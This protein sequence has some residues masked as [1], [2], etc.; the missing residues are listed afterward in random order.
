MGFNIG[1]TMRV[2]SAPNYYEPRDSIARD[3]PRFIKYLM[4]DANLFLIPNIEEDAVEFCRNH[5][6]NM[7]ILTGG[8]DYGVHNERD[9]TEFALI[10][11]M[12]KKKLPIIGI[13]RGM[14]VIHCFFGGKV[15]QGDD[16]FIELHRATKHDIN[17]YG[18]VI[19]VNS[20]HNLKIDES[21]LSK[22]FSVLARCLEDG[23][24]EGF[25]G[26]NILGMMW[27]PERTLCFSD[28][29]KNLIINFL[30]RP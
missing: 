5:N 20:Y 28:F 4:P 13:C 25:I 27:H 7:L 2:T 22:K 10:E 14:Q 9:I 3:W 16:A 18:N 6:I 29:S 23:S 8:N 11:Y 19:E 1:I 17:V 30:N 26:N 24:I 21:T 15:L 12:H